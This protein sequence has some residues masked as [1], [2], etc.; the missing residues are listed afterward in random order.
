MHLSV[1]LIL[2]VLLLLLSATFSGSESAYFSITPWRLQRLH[3]EGKEYATTAVEMLKRPERLLVVILF[4]NETVNALVSQLGAVINRRYNPEYVTGLTI[5]FTL[6]FTSLLMVFGEISPK[7]I[8]ITRPAVYIR[9]TYLL[10]NIWWKF[11][12]R[13]S[14]FVER[15]TKKIIS[16][17]GE[18]TLL[19]RRKTELRDEIH[20]FIVLGL[21]E[22]IINEEEKWLLDRITELDRL[23]VREIMTPRHLIDA[24][25]ENSTIKDAIDLIAEKKH[26]RILIYKDTI[27]EITGKVV[28][29]DLIKYLKSGRDLTTPINKLAHTVMHVPVQINLQVLLS[30]MQRRQ[31]TMAVV[32]DEY[33]GTIGLATLEDVIEEVVGDIRDHI[34]E[35]KDL[36]ME[37]DDGTYLVDAQV[38][39][40]DLQRELNFVNDTPFAAL[41]GYLMHLFGRLP[42]PGEEVSDDIFTYKIVSVKKQ[43]IKQVKLIPHRGSGIIDREER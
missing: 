28:L 21:D 17:K 5:L 33:G 14:G 38:L 41:H 26:S 2:L 42:E 4:G 10:L 27:D 36:I 39:L 25:D 9:T 13:L 7:G 34:E 1:L 6:I 19:T 43:R 16:G 12:S 24:L 23:T 30:E 40:R 20:R 3:R 18:K 22:G 32:F 35:E 15:I 11:T 37:Q 29:K 8:A 31:E